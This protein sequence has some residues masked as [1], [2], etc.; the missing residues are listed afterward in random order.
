M[1]KCRVCKDNTEVVFN[2]GFKATPICESCATAIF[3]QQ[4]TWY[5]QQGQNLPI[6]RVINCKPEQKAALNGAV[7]AIYFADNSD[8]LSG[9]YEVVR[10][11]T[12]L[13]EPTDEDIEMLY[14][15]LNPD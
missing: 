13:D 4:A 8:Y 10:S 11:L 5:T 6:Q 3:I 2:I 15:E 9:L 14:N 12:N 7:K 1:K